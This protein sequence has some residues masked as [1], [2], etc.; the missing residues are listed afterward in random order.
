MFIVGKD[1]AIVLWQLIFGNYLGF[2]Q[3]VSLHAVTQP[4]DILVLL[5]LSLWG[6]SATGSAQLVSECKLEPDCKAFFTLVHINV[7]IG[8]AYLAICVFLKPLFVAVFCVYCG[9]LN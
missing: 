8:Y 2:W 7:I 6:S 5:V 4:I 1:T 3:A 9:G